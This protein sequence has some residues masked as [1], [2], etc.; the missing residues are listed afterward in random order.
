MFIIKTTKFKKK[1][2]KDKKNLKKRIVQ[3]KKNL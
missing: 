2:K 3:K 1:V